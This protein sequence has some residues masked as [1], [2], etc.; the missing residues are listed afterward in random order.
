MKQLT[1][2]T[3]SLGI[4]LTGDGISI[5]EEYHK[6]EKNCVSSAEAWDLN[7][8]IDLRGYIRLGMQYVQFCHNQIRPFPRHM[9]PISEKKNSTSARNQSSVVHP[10]A[11]PL[12]EGV[13]LSKDFNQLTP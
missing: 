2:Q 12:T 7:S 1:S 3:V 8:L 9:Y 10:P 13:P 11:I 6:K 4:C 5:S